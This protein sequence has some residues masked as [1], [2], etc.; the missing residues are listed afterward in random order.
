MA[1]LIHKVRHYS[2]ILRKFS[3][4]WLPQAWPGN[5]RRSYGYSRNKS[6]EWAAGRQACP[7]LN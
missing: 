4:P 1:A 5:L 7:L 3:S 6:P 2:N